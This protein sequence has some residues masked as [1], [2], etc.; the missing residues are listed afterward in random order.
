V[1]ADLAGRCVL[2]AAD[3]DTYGH[4]E[5]EPVAEPEYR[6]DCDAEAYA[7]AQADEDP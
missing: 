6:S 4:A 3:R 1:P 7:N 5:P 2:T